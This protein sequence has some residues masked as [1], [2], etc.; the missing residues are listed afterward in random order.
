[1]ASYITTTEVWPLFGHDYVTTT[2]H[3]GVDNP[4]LSFQIA[5]VFFLVAMLSLCCAVICIM[6]GNGWWCCADPDDWSQW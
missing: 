1:M 5:G 2:V 4:Y 6:T 3:P